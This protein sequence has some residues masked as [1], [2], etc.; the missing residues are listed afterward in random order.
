[1]TGFEMTLVEH[2]GAWRYSFGHRYRGVAR[3]TPSFLCSAAACVPRK[4]VDLSR[5]G[6]GGLC[7]NSPPSSRPVGVLNNTTFLAANPCLSRYLAHK[8]QAAGQD[9]GKKR[10]LV[11]SLL[12]FLGK[13]FIL[14]RPQ[15]DLVP[16]TTW[17]ENAPVAQQLLCSHA[18]THLKTKAK[19][20]NVAGLCTRSLIILLD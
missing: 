7:D 3:L 5:D 14:S 4:P 20:S 18:T 9:F 16:M 12:G 10:N 17:C 6:K 13:V 2:S 11:A 15:Q 8:G 19:S 1:M